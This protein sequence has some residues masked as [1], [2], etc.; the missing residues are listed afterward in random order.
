MSSVHVQSS[1]VQ[2]S[3]VQ[4]SQVQFSTAQC[5]TVQCSTVQSGPVQFSSVQSSKVQSSAVWS[6]LH[7][8]ELWTSVSYS[9][10]WQRSAIGSH[11][12]Q[13]L[14]SAGDSV[15]HCGLPTSTHT[16]FK[17]SAAA[18]VMIMRLCSFVNSYK[19]KENTEDY[20]LT[21]VEQWLSD[22]VAHMQLFRVW[23]KANV[24][25]FLFTVQN[26]SMGKA[27]TMML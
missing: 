27:M 8:D 15:K 14:I 5:S 9:G 1:P 16:G 18:V 24:L 20:R 13:L 17:L 3:Q 11:L 21:G 19:N 26:K 22:T 10:C 23:S 7:K 12:S 2:Y 25:Q 6:D 4:Y